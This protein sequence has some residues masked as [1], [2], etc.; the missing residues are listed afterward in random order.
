MSSRVIRSTRMFLSVVA[1]LIVLILVAACTGPADQESSNPQ[2]SVSG[3]NGIAANDQS[4]QEGTGSSNVQTNQAGTSGKQPS[5]ASAIT[6]I[7]ACA[8]YSWLAQTSAGFSYESGDGSRVDS[9]K[10]PPS[11]FA[12]E[13]GR[14]AEDS[15]E[16]A[17]VGDVSPACFIESKTPAGGSVYVALS[18]PGAPPTGVASAVGE[19]MKKRGANVVGSYS[20]TSTEGTFDLVSL[21]GI[22]AE[23][24]NKLP[25]TGA[26]YFITTQEGTFQAVMLVSYTDIGSG[27]VSS[28]MPNVPA[29]PSSTLAPL[30]ALNVVPVS[31]TGMAGDINDDLKPALK[32]AL[33]VDLLVQS[34]F[35]SSAGGNDTATISYVIHGQLPAGVDLSAA[36]SEVVESL[37]G[38][39]SFAFASAEGTSVLFE[40][41]NAGEFSVGGGFTYVPSTGQIAVTLTSINNQ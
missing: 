13:V 31:P 38:T 21:Q 36:L 37:G 6:G 4:S 10:T 40:G 23:T 20:S 22:P 2:E 17:L 28:G 8:S 25:T 33:G 3:D 19:A 30:P 11:D 32:N 1:A 35:Q 14:F 15:L 5:T 26:L 39:V 12:A 29:A 41:I 27:Q 7:D 16:E 18:L 9:S 24:P 34:F